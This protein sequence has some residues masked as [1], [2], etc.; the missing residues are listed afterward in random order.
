MM[1][2]GGPERPWAEGESRGSHSIFI[3]RNLDCGV[4]LAGLPSCITSPAHSA[5]WPLTG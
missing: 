2:D 1:L 5:Y 4:L 3:S